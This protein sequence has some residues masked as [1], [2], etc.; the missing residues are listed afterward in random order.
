MKDNPFK[1]FATPQNTI[2]VT[3]SSSDLIVQLSKQYSDLQTYEWEIANSY[4]ENFEALVTLALKTDLSRIL[5]VGCGD[6]QVELVISLMA[7]GRGFDVFL[8]A[9]NVDGDENE[10]RLLQERLRQ[11]GVVIVSMSQ[12]SCEFNAGMSEQP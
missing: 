3:A 1:H 8:C 4:R 12:I 7:I 11:Q 2:I 5:I 10:T 6:D 9:D